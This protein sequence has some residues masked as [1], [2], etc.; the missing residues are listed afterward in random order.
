M[1]LLFGQYINKNW[2]KE[3]EKR[4]GNLGKKLLNVFACHK[5]KDRSLL[6]RKLTSEIADTLF[7]WVKRILDTFPTVNVYGN[8][9]LSMQKFN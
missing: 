7:S 4:K 9:N 3:I 2:E 1:F 5:S 6:P 8:I